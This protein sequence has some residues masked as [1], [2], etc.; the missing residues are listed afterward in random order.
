MAA[1]RAAF[2]DIS[3]TTRGNRPLTEML[4]VGK[5]VKIQQEKKPSMLQQP[6]QKPLLISNVSTIQP[7]SEVSQNAQPKTVLAKRA[8][9]IFKDYSTLAQT[10]QLEENVSRKSDS[11][12][13]PYAGPK[14]KV[15]VQLPEL[16]LKQSLES[17]PRSHSNLLAGLA[18]LHIPVVHAEKDRPLPD[19][20]STAT[21]ILKKSDALQEMPVIVDKRLAEAKIMSILHSKDDIIQQATE[22]LPVKVTERN[23]YFDSQAY[24]EEDYD[25]NLEDDGYVTARSYRSR[26]DNNTEGNFTTILKPRVSREIERELQAAAAV[27]SLLREPSGADDDDW[28]ISMVSEYKDEIFDYYQELEVSIMYT[29]KKRIL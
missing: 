16:I 13:Q 14:S 3:Q 23:E 18:D 22:P 5:D 21:I 4:L 29:L 1:K 24:I 26:P 17:Y 20:V 12:A 11:I 28:D 7:L 2:G 27:T 19:I 6:A 15:E 8:T 25:E 10:T 9:T